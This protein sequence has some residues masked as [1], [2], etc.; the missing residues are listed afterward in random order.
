MYTNSPYFRFPYPVCPG[1]GR[2]QYCG[3]GQSHYE[4]FQHIPIPMSYTVVSKREGRV[5][6]KSQDVTGNIN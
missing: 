4:Y 5:S 6:D 2:C 1:C 3:Q